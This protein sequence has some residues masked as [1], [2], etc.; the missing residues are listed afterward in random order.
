MEASVSGSMLLAA[1]MLKLGVYGI[2]R[3]SEVFIPPL[4]WVF[5]LQA[6]GVYGGTVAVFVAIR[7]P[8]LKSV[9]AYASV[10]HISLS[11]ARVFTFSFGAFQG[12]YITIIRH[13]LTSSGLFAWA[14]IIY[15]KVGTRNLLVMSG[16]REFRPEQAGALV[17]LIMANC[18]IPP[19]LSFFGEVFVFRSL[20]LYA[21]WLGAFLIGGVSFGLF[22]FIY[23]FIVVQHSEHFMPFMGKALP[24]RDRE[25]LVLGGHLVP[26][27]LLF[28]CPAFVEI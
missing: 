21:P 10:S 23:L 25:W 28:F 19:F 7:Q 17:L 22:C 6:L 2:F 13:G 26:L 9:I 14:G 27:V 12:V 8:D 1:V 15:G 5:P 16:L 4:R 3:Y 20:F 18:G 24:I 11:V